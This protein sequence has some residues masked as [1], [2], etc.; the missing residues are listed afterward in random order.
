MESNERITVNGQH[1]IIRNS[2]SLDNGLYSCQFRQAT[3]NS[4]LIERNF[5]LNVDVDQSMHNGDI[6]D[7]I[8]KTP[9][10]CCKNGIIE[11]HKNESHVS[12]GLYLCRRKRSDRTQEFISGNIAP[13]NLS[14]QSETTITIDENESVTIGC[15]IG[16]GK[17]TP[18]VIQWE[19]DGKP[20]RQ[21]DINSPPDSG[22]IEG[23]HQ[24]EDGEF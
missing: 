24:R 22:N 2:T 18:S 19:K 7:R 9:S 8:V 11:M 14:K 4:K 10:G 13:E 3:G 16:K 12:N 23:T 17:K 6:L 21:I 15:D 1:L 5:Q 20:F